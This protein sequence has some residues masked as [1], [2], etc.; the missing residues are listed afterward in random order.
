MNSRFLFCEHIFVDLGMSI[1]D[2]EIT[3]FGSFRKTA[4]NITLV[5]NQG[6]CMG[7]VDFR[8]KNFDFQ[9][10]SDQM[11]LGGPKYISEQLRTFS[12]RFRKNFSFFLFFLKSRGIFSKVLHVKNDFSGA[13]ICPKI[14][15]ESKNAIFSKSKIMIP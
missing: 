10:L 15:S 4:E 12:K 1:C 8:R 2:I 3:Q 13:V 5:G 14:A 7:L 9:F 11:V 6:G